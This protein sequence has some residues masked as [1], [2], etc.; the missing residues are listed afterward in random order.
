MSPSWFVR[1][2]H[3]GSARALTAR[4]Q[5]RAPKFLKKPA[6]PEYE[7]WSGFEDTPTVDGSTGGVALE[8]GAAKPGGLQDPLEADVPFAL[9]EEEATDSTDVSAWRPLL[10]SDTM[11]Y[12]LSK[13]GF[14]NPTPIQS[15]TIPKILDGHD[16]IGKA[17]TGSGK[18]LAYGVPI[19]E[20]WLEAAPDSGADKARSPPGPIALVL[21]P[22][23]ELA[24][25]IT[26]HL[27][28][29][30]QNFP[31]RPRVA[32]VT[33]GLSVHKQMRLLC[34]VDVVVG[35]PG[36]LWEI[37]NESQDFTDRL[38]SI[39]FLIVD[40][41]DR[42]LSEGHFKEVE[43]I[44]VTL[45]R[46]VIEEDQ[47]GGGAGQE[48]A[49]GKRPRQTLVFSATFHKSLQQKL[50]GK[51]RLAGGD[52][53]TDKQ[54]VE[55]LLNKLSF[56]EKRPA[57][58]DV[59]PTSQMA[60]AL[61]EAILECGPMEKD[62]YLYLLLLLNPTAKALVFTN[63]I[64]SVKRIVPLLQNLNLPA[65]AL[66][67]SMAQKARLRSL[68]RFSAQRTILVATDVA[69]RG[70]DI[71][72]I[73]L[74][75]HYHVPRTADA[76][77]HRSG[78]T[79]RAENPGR[80]VLLCAPAEVAGVTKLIVKIHEGHHK[81][82]PL[83]AD[84]ETAARLRPRLSLAQKI[85]DA[86]LSREQAA[87]KENWLR[88]AAEELGV[89]YDSD[90]FAAETARGSRGKKGP[91]EKKSSRG[92]AAASKATIAGWKAQLRELL[93]RRVNLGVSEKYIAAGR[94]DVNALLDGE[95][96]DGI[97]LRPTRSMSL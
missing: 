67:S 85:T 79:A 80:S 76:Y 54:S 73:D 9:L 95:R 75:I 56:R 30:S 38:K 42:L 2:W 19:F 96:D 88:N 77:V 66:H 90:E 93:A 52:L 39:D 72:L 53:L 20:K 12:A 23:R 46:E 36:R 31:C 24:H 89:D 45:D 22:T 44:L 57:F 33:G 69:A 82:E 64:S 6:E 16:V 81:M 18:T 83:K 3:L 28:D 47:G 48:P 61:N 55:Y 26:K 1:R 37:M 35:T 10:I 34:E 97:F 40:E 27:F 63:S 8:N 84:R 4:D 60:A 50:S 59:N 49:T 87:T 5:A 94:V 51:G 7:E 32:T 68:E 21:S 86:T 62:L 11:A 41:A 70:L 74:I 14:S 91:A 15:A 43:Q 13:L 65:L 25:Q 29:L 71:K 58:I 17:V 92:D 78:R